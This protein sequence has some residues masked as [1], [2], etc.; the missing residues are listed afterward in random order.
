[1]SNDD[2]SRESRDE[3]SP[4]MEDM[5]VTLEVS[6][7]DKSTL[8]SRIQP[9]NNRSMLVTLDVSHSDKSTDTSD[10]LVLPPMSNIPVMFVTDDVSNADN[11]SKSEK[12]AKE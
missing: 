11:P 8:L 5:V 12:P 10:E 7:D 4:N 1:M 2:K 6:S 9:L 3:Q